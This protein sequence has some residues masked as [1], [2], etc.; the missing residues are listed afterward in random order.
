MPITGRFDTEL[1]SNLRISRYVC[2]SSFPYVALPTQSTI[3]QGVRPLPDS[4]PVPIVRPGGEESVRVFARSDTIRA[5]DLGTE[6]AP[7]TDNPCRMTTAH[8][9]IPRSLLCFSTTLPTA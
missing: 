2:G 8:R 9:P 4:A 5:D 7:W 6:T 1:S 3:V